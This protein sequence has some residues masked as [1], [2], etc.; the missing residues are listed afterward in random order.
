[1]PDQANVFILNISS[2][3]IRSHLVEDKR[4]NIR[5]TMRFEPI[6][7]RLRAVSFTDGARR[8]MP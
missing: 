6:T 5:H 1:V 8:P 3:W 7:A 2:E 4:K